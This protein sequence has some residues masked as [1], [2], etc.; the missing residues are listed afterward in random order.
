MPRF[1]CV[2]NKPHPVGNERHTICCGLTSILWISH[3]LEGKYCPQH[4]CRK[5]YN[6]RNLWIAVPPKCSSFRRRGGTNVRKRYV[7]IGGGGQAY[8][9]YSYPQITVVREIV[10]SM[11][12]MCRPNFGSGKAIAFESGFFVTKN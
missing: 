9:G 2:G 11:L 1:M 4:L 10:S 6:Y 12:R 7:Q 3:I 8:G 5:E